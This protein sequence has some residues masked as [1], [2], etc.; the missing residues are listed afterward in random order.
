MIDKWSSV[1]RP[2]FIIV[3]TQINTPMKRI[4]QAKNI[5]KTRY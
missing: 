2:F 5:L 1:I 4:I 3:L